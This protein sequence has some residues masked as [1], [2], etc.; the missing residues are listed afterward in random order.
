[1]A[2]AAGGPVAGM[3]AMA[4]GKGYWLVTVYGRVF[5]FGGAQSYGPQDGVPG[6]TSIVG[7]ASAPSADGYWLV[8]STGNVFSF[9]KATFHGSGVGWKVPIVGM[10]ATP[11]GGGYWLAA[12][13]GGVLPFGNAQFHG[14]AASMHLG[15]AVVGIG[16]AP[17]GKGYWLVTAKGRVI[18]FGGAANFGSMSQRAHPRATITGIA[19][20]ADGRGYWLAAKDGGVF[21]FGDASFLGSES[22]K[23]PVGQWVGA[24]AASPT[25]VAKSTTTTTPATSTTGSTPTT[26][27]RVTTTAPTSPATVVTVAPSSP[28]LTVCGNS[29]LLASPYASAPRGAVTVPAGDDSTA[30]MSSGGYVVQNFDVN[31]RTTYWFA[32]GTHTLGTGDY[33][34]IQPADGDTFIGAPGAVI[35]GQDDNESAFDGTATGVT[36]E[37]LTV[38]G[39]VPPGSQGTVNHDSGADWTVKYDTIEDNGNTAGS[40]DG[41]ALMMGDGDV[42]E[43]NCLT[44]NGEYALNA[45]DEN[46]ANGG[47]QGTTFAYNEV[48]YNGVADFPDVS[49]CGCSGGIKY[50]ASTGAVV[51][52]NYIHDNYNVGLWFDTDN[53]GALVDGNYIA[54]NW[55]EGAVY[56][57]SYNADITANTFLDNG[58][59]VGSYSGPA[60]FP[61]G[62]GL[63]INGSA[64]DAALDGGLYS[65]LA[66]TANVFTDNW[67]G[68][69]IYQNPDRI[70]GTPGNSSTGSCTLVDPS[71]YNTTSCGDWAAGASPTG[72]S[73]DP[74]Y[75]DG[76]QWK[77]NNIDVSGNTFNFN[78][79]DIINGSSAVDLPDITYSDCYSGPNFRDT[80]AAPPTGN[81]YWCGFNGMFAAGGSL[82]PFTG[83][84]G[85]YV[86][87]AAIMGKTGSSGEA[88]DTNTWAHNT[89]AGPWAFQAYY[90]G[91]SPVTSDI[92]PAGV[93]TTLD[94][95]S[96][97][98][99]WGM[100]VGSTESGS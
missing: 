58:W 81:D 49:S 38:E 30:K 23:L 94:F 46:E 99:V 78:P 56:E 62:D 80:S 66:V 27:V 34:Q 95:K 75:Y 13:N 98:S 11:S 53:V 86:V 97:Q 54:A 73:G 51:A 77:A 25:S 71:V 79:S 48:S 89:Y 14:S 39:F 19:V 4:G 37:Y 83:N 16:A 65:P 55:A 82:A 63:Y 90:Q 60:D 9:G 70:C 18:A 20:S 10:A 45:Y 36:I 52:D 67:D 17:N 85:A 74:D 42:Y 43:Y 15:S 6:G 69:V 76:C 40:G 57:I 87:A 32:P 33:S 8:S 5:A 68:I 3:A 61:L 29:S 1:M 96:W 35:S 22:G 26:T 100:D 28:P 72:P 64:G 31:P 21:P 88:P 47:P 2:Q 44:N 59:G 91:T 50:W 92:Y 24:I 41:G 93:Q 84:V 12:S 7:M